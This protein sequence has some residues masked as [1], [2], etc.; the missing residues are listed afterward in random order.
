MLCS[1]LAEQRSKASAEL[2]RASHTRQAPAEFTHSSDGERR[3]LSPQ[4]LRKA[5]STAVQGLRGTF[6]QHGSFL[7]LVKFPTDWPP[8]PCQAFLMILGLATRLF[9]IA[10]AAA[11]GSLHSRAEPVRRPLLAWKLAGPGDL[12]QV[13]Y[14]PSCMSCMHAVT[15]PALKEASCQVLHDGHGSM[16]MPANRL[17][18]QHSIAAPHVKA[19][20]KAIRLL[21]T[22]GLLYYEVRKRSLKRSL[23]RASQNVPYEQK[24]DSKHVAAGLGAWEL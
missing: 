13:S 15:K 8:W 23:K 12:L 21:S 19:A 17:V 18:P 7:D 3:H 9:T 20:C 2:A 11:Q 24:L 1:H 16:Y 4:T 10:A 14:H 22:I 6:F 5:A